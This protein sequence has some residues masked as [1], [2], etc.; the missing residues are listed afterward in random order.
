MDELRHRSGGDEHKYTTKEERLEQEYYELGLFKLCK[1]NNN[2][3]DK[4]IETLT[5]MAK[6]DK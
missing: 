5:K 1:D 2:N 4:A 6:E 3:P